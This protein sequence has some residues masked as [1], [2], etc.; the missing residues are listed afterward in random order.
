LTARVRDIFTDAV[1]GNN[2]KYLPS[3]TPVW[4]K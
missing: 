3:C 1:R 2:K 4:A